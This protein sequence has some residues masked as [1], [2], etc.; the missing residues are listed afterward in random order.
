MNSAAN[1]GFLLEDFRNYGAQT[2]VIWKD[3]AVTYTHILDRIIFWREKFQKRYASKIVGLESD[4]SPE[5][6]AM[7]FALIDANAIVVPFDILHSEKNQKKYGIAQLDALIRIREENKPEFVDF[8]DT[9]A[10]NPLYNSILTGSKPGLVLF[11]SGSSGEPKGALH[12]FQKLLNKF[13]TKRKALRTVNFLLFD[14]WG[15]LNTL[16][17]ILSNGGTV[18]ILENR[19]PDYVCETIEKHQVE[20]LP[21]SPTFLNMLVLSRAYERFPLKSLKLI[22][23]GAE[24]MPESLLKRLNTLFP[25]IKLQQTYGLIEL[26][27]LRSQ[28]EENGSLWV[29]IGGE[30]YQTRVV[31]NLLQIKSDSAMLGYLNAPSPFTEDG[32][33]M[34][35]DTVEVKGDYMKIL[36]RKSEI[37]NVGGEK[38]FP[39]EVENVILEIPDVED[40]LVYSENNPLTG[41]IVCAKIK[42]KGPDTRAELIKKVKTYC[43]TKLETFKVPVKIEL[44]DQSFESGR[45]KKSRVSG[46]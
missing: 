30:G 21:T 16:F 23:Y 14:H 18:V 19:T 15:G 39:Q 41:K 37:I 27:V 17:H 40:V 31:D 2:A 34:T 32:W 3:Q 4:F 33:F 13:R 11:T 12:D 44:A 22:S 45:F 10:K 26:G 43:R 1:I 20:L 5:T 42:Y 24:P 35:G 36:G 28:S 8:T 46:N 29:K 7:L 25:D 6:I 9:Q 38:V